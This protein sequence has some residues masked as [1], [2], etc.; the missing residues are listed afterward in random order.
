MAQK[1]KKIKIAI[2]GP[3]GSGKSTIAQNLANLLNINYLNS[4]ALYRIIGYYLNERKIDP[5][6]SKIIENILEKLNIEIKNN[7]YFLDGKDVTITIKDSKIG[8]LA[9]LY[10]KNNIVREKVN[11]II[12][13]IAEK[14]NIVVDGR[15]IG[16]VVLPDSDIKI[17]LTASLEER[18][19]RRWNEEKEQKA[20]ISFTEILE[21]IKNRDYNDSNRSIAP[22]KRAQD[23]IIIDTTNLSIEEVLQKILKIV[24]ESGIYGD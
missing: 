7:R 10:S 3:A 4:G 20:N 17:Y 2:D 9:S 6:D 5:K 23:A 14:D 8:D 18:A 24:K 21:E 12:K 19:K 15:D 13:K 22:L 1:A 11:Q 16:T